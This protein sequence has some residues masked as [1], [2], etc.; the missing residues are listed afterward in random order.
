MRPPKGYLANPPSKRRNTQFN[1]TFSVSPVEL[2]AAAA[3]LGTLAPD[4][5][6]KEIVYRL[7]AELRIKRTSDGE[8]LNVQ[9]SWTIAAVE[10]S[11]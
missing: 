1:M 6:R 2:A 10:S 5:E 3:Q 11:R 8:N 9:T 4:G 7:R